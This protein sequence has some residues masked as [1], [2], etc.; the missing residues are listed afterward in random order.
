MKKSINKRTRHLA[1]VNVVGSNNI[2]QFIKY[3]VFFG[4]IEYHL[5]N[6][7]YGD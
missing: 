7:F 4:I 2:V 5:L 3:H 6:I 1:P